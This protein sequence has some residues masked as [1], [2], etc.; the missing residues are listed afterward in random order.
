M[1]CNGQGVFNRACKHTPCHCFNCIFKPAAVNILHNLCIA[2]Q[3]TVLN[4]IVIFVCIF[5]R[6]FF[7]C[8]FSKACNMAEHFLTVQSGNARNKRFFTFLKSCAYFFL[9]RLPNEQRAVLCIGKKNPSLFCKF[10][11]KVKNLVFRR[12][13]HAFKDCAAVC[14][15]LHIYA[16]SPGYVFCNVCKRQ[17]VVFRRIK[18]IRQSGIVKDCT[19]RIA[20]YSDCF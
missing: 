6:I 4:Q 1:P 8:C 12:N 13:F 15:F 18:R 7:F 3:N 2:T 19:K 11:E 5:F 10:F 20:L 17:A 14:F 9:L 16:K